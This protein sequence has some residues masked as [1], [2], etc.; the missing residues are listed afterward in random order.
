MSDS[1]DI[2]RKRTMQKGLIWW[3][4]RMLLDS[5]TQ[6][7]ALHRL[8]HFFFSRGIPLLPALIRRFN[9]FFTG[10]DIYPSCYMG[11][12]ISL[13][14]SVGIVIADKTIINDNCEIFGQVILGGRG[15]NHHS[16]GAPEIGSNTVLCIGAKILGPVSVGDN[17][18]VAAGAVVLS[19][20]PD[21]CLAAGVPATI[22]PTIK[23]IK[24]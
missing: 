5:G 23:K 19:S 2:Q 21:N 17:V 11:K 1:Q 14:H 10:A 22:K 6:A 13:I 9:I 8:A 16:D 15:G 3:I 20:V 24:K 4:G 12:G 7:M 18:T